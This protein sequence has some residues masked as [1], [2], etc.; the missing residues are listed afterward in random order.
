MFAGN[1]NFR[2][3]STSPLIDRG[4]DNA[5]G[6]MTDVDLDGLPRVVGPAVDIGAYESGSPP[7]GP[8]IGPGISGNWF[9]P[10]PNQDGHGFQI[11]VLPNNGMLAVWFV[12]NPQ[13]TGQSWIYTQGAYN[14]GSNSVTL[15]AFLETGGRFPPN[16]SNSTLITMPWGSLTFTFSDCSNGTAIWQSNAD[17]AAAGYGDVSFP[18]RRLTSLAGTS[19]P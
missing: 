2:L 13:G 5:A 18:I 1:G 15:P 8:A 11:E 9:D 3:S 4:H 16:F 14:A 6:G 19:C 17:S 10:T 7:A 12:F